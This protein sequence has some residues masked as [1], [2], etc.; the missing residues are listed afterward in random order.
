MILLKV[1][2]LITEGEIMHFQK[3]IKPLVDGA[4][5]RRLFKRQEYLLQQSH[6]LMKKGTCKNSPGV[7]WK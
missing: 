5:S 1:T 3:E 6:I 4:G 2:I 7:I